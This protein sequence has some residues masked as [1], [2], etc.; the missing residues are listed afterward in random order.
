MAHRENLSI[1]IIDPNLKAIPEFLEPFDYD[2][3]IHHACCGA[4]HWIDYSKSQKWDS[5]QIE[6][7][8]KNTPIRGEIKRRVESLVL[9][10]KFNK[11]E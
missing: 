5:E 2:S 10:G 6:A 9:S 8:K 1:R 11:W 4:A 3:R 7:L